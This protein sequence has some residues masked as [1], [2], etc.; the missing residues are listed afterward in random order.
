MATYMYHVIKYLLKNEKENKFKICQS[1]LGKYK[2]V[3]EICE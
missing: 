2:Q 3:I 1:V